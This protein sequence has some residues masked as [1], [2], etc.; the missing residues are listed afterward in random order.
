M[1]EWCC[2]RGGVVSKNNNK[3]PSS[4]VKEARERNRKVVFNFMRP[5]DGDVLLELWMER[6]PEVGERLY[7]IFIGD[8]LFEH[9]ILRSGWYEIRT[10]HGAPGKRRFGLAPLVNYRGGIDPLEGQCC[11]AIIVTKNFFF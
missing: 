2:N 6:V 4:E 10:G 1:K 9:F 11:Y 3:E 7:L 5:S 8:M